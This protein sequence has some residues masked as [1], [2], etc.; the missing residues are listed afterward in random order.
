ME[1]AGISMFVHYNAERW[2]K[3]IVSE[4]IESAQ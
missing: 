1:I 4:L 3:N 2:V